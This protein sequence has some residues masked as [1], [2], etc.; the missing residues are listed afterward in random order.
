MQTVAHCPQCFSLFPQ[1]C[2]KTFPSEAVAD[3]WGNDLTQL[4]L[5]I[6]RDSSDLA[7]LFDESNPAITA[8]IR[9]LIERAH[10]A[11][12]PVGLCGQ[13]PSDHPEFAAF[14]VEAGID[15][16]SLNPDSVVRVTQIV[17][18]A[19]AAGEAPAAG[20]GGDAEA[21]GAV[22]APG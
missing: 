11:G 12:R 16:I 21:V 3:G 7:D 19:E 6:D 9:A 20:P 13:A 1:F 17:A 15:S 5:G 18:E 10:A 2:F 14:L 22:P 4:T 8:M